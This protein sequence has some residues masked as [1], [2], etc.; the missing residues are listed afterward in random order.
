M[1]GSDNRING[2]IVLAFDPKYQERKL[3]ERLVSPSELAK[4]LTAINTLF[5]AISGLF[6]EKHLKFIKLNDKLVPFT[7][8]D[9]TYLLKVS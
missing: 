6:Y 1:I 4:K 7:R 9:L 3:S 2:R 5:V 8:K